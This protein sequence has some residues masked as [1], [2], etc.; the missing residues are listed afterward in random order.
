M[1]IAMYFVLAQYFSI[2]LGNMKFTL[3]SLPILVGASLFGPVDGLLIGLCGSFLDQL[4]GYGLM[5]TTVLWIAPAAIRG[6]LVGLY[7]KSHRYEMSTKQTVFITVSTALL[8]TALNTLVMWLDSVI[9]DYYSF[10]YIFG[11]VP[12][13]IVAGILTA[14]VFAVILPKLLP[15]L[16]RFLI[17]EENR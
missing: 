8:V 17:T 1:L 15:P 11:A 5:P 14:V 7:A 13:R 9:Y 16:R 10:A 12:T 4:M 3:D 2:K 6:L